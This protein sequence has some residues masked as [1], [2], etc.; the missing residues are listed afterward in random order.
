MDLTP[1]Q[2]RFVDEYL[3]DLNATQAA[4]RA[5]YSAKTAASQGERLLRNVD[6]AAAIAAAK[7]ARTERTEVDADY[8]LKRMIEIDQMDVLDIMDDDMAI[9]PVSEWPKVWRQYLS[10]FDLAEMFEG[11]GEQREMIGIL[12][13][14]KWPDKVK[15]LELL[16]RHFGMFKDK[17]EHSGEIKTPELKLVLN[18]TRPPPAAE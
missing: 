13:K 16:G 1:R 6:V 10:G 9:K 17:V 15:N 7:K 5:G 12:K 18:G 14:I 4:T 11:R 8:V 3:I 2:Q